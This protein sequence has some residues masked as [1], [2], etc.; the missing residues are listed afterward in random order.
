MTST[1]LFA[2]LLSALVY[3][4]ADLQACQQ[5]LQP[6]AMMLM[7]FHGV[8]PESLREEIL[9]HGLTATCSVLV[10]VSMCLS[11]A[12]PACASIMPQHVRQA[13]HALISIVDFMCVEEFEIINANLDCLMS[14]ELTQATYAQCGR[15]SGTDFCQVLQISECSV[16]LVAETCGEELGDVTGNFVQ[17]MQSEFGCNDVFGFKYLKKMLR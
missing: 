15:T 1:L 4:E 11:N 6:C 10:E 7:Q 9:Q 2:L 16:D 13:F 14:Q 17:R 8:T 5:S 12:Q 3:T